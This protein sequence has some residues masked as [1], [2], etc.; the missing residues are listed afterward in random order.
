M[1]EKRIYVVVADTV[2]SPLM[3]SSDYR[4]PGH[5]GIVP[6]SRTK[7][8]IQPKGR[9]AAQ[10]GHV[11]SLMRMMCLADMNNAWAK[12]ASNGQKNL[13]KKLS[14]DLSAEVQRPYTTIILAAPDSYQLRFRRD[15][16]ER[17]GLRVHAFYDTNDEYNVDPFTAQQVCTA[18]CTQPIEPE[19]AG[20]ALDY[21]SLWR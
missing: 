11:V 20:S 1:N 13:A 17:E 8:I 4:Y 18:I 9:I 15:L 7:T 14:E 16:L 21:L 3:Q 2:Q 12:A 10:V 5:R 19:A 6:T